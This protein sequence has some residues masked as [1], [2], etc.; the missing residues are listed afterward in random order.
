MQGNVT[1]P[2]VS[3]GELLA[4]K[5]RVERTLGE[6][7]MG[8]VVA[9]T[10]VA[11]GTRV[12]IKLLRPAATVSP[13][14]LGRFQREANAAARLRSEHVA[15]AIDVGTLP[16]GRPYMVMEYLE[17]Q[18]LADFLD[19]NGP[20]PIW[21]AVDFLLQACEAIAEA[22][23]AGIIHRDLKPRNL[24]LTTTVDG[25]P[26]VKV[27]DFGIS[28]I[29][30]PGEDMQLTKTTEVIGSP[31]YMSPEQLRASRDVDTRTDIWA[32]GVILYELL[33]GKLPFY[34]N[35]V[36]ELVA[37]V[38]METHPPLKTYRADVPEPLE[39]ILARCLGKRPQDRYSSVGEL[40]H[41][42][43]PFASA[44]GASV[45]DRVVGVALQSGRLSG[46]LPPAPGV[47]PPAASSSRVNV[48]GGTSVAW[49]ETQV[50]AHKGAGS[51]APLVLGGVAVLLLVA[52]GA[53]G[54]TAWYVKRAAAVTAEGAQPATSNA[55]L[56]PSAQPLPLP[57]G[58]KDLP[59]LDAPSAT[60]A[61]S[62][63]AA[64][65]AVASTLPDTRKDPS[66]SPP[67]QGA[68]KAPTSR[69]SKPPPAA[70]GD[71]LSNIGRR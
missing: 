46:A 48:H 38:L 10:N 32:L 55:A 69:P 40:A 27:L 71:P 4:G 26:H 18:D 15:R 21:E 63:S 3:S 20:R 50:D 19:K 34:A 36:T 24:F 13:E 65:S 62:A 51:R 67:A 52:A 41:V 1:M 22:H 16:D 64:P 7:G 23:A 53:A 11:L 70:G 14:A 54:G 2:V 28:K 35:T 58:R 49:G 6:G 25:R 5:Y 45:A 37:V 17:G 42:L 56:P 57:P 9:A 47:V 61:P 68:A 12:A 60:A 31:S 43:K 44:L 66:P 30:G 8:V 59:P 39:A 29:E 33:T